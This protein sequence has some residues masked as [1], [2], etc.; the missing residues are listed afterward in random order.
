MRYDLVR[1]CANCPFRTDGHG[2]L[3]AERAREIARSL[4]GGA[5]F[6][7][8]VTTEDTDEGG[9]VAV[10]TSHFCAG[11]L[12]ALER[13]GQPNQMMRIAERLGIYDA[14]KLDMTSPVG[15]TKDFIARH[16]IDEDMEE[17]EPCEICGPGCEAPAGWME[18]G[19]V[20]RNVV[21]AGVTQWCDDCQTTH[22][23]ACG[24][25]D[26]DYDPEA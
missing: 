20:V 16:T 2:Y 10:P 7:C 21:E 19:A 22:C 26:P 8:H 15:T 18:G 1:P 25:N 14:S 11:A 3:R 6:P 17:G 9:R 12:I 13:E 24:C 23:G 4:H 5:E